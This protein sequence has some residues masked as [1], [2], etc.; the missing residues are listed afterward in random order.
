MLKHL[1]DKIAFV[2][3]LVPGFQLPKFVA[4]Y[5]QRL[6]GRLEQAQMDL[7]PFQAIADRFHGGDLDVMIDKHLR[8]A[9]PTFQAEGE[10]IQDMALQVQRLSEAAAA[11]DGPLWERLQYLSL[12][13]DPEL[14]RATLSVYEP[15]MVVTPEAVICALLVGFILMLGVHLLA[16]I[17]RRLFRRRPGAGSPA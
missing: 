4:D 10:V 7:A 15:G 17:L 8:S 16:G 3:G 1:L 6:G 9:D 12:H 13:G 2:G 5:R 14:A 11:L